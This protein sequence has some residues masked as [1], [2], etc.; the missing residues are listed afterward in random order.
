MQDFLGERANSVYL[1]G[2]EKRN[3]EG[4]IAKIATI[5]DG[6]YCNTLLQFYYTFYVAVT[7]QHTFVF[8]LATRERPH[9]FILLSPSKALR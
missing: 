5:F 7:L 6:I 8:S 4:R 3:G 1:G 2:F 9:K